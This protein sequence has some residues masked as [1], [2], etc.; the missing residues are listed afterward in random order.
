MKKLILIIICLAQT[1]IFGQSEA[2]AVHSKFKILKQN[3]KSPLEV[4]AACLTCHNK[5]HLEIMKSSHWTWERKNPLPTR[6]EEKVLGK[7]NLLNNFCIGIAGSEGTCTKCHIGYGWT[8]EIPT[9]DKNLRFEKYAEK[10][11]NRIDCLVCHDNSGTYKKAKGKSGYPKPDINLSLVAQNIGKPTNENCGSCHFFS[12]G[13]NNVK[14]GDLEKALLTCSRKVDIHMSEDGANLDCIDCHK[15]ENHNITGQLYSVSSTNEDRAKCEACHTTTPH[16]DELLNTHYKKISCQTCHI[17]T[18]AKANAT[19]I[20]WD[21]STAGKLNEDDKPYHVNDADGN[22]SYLSIKGSFKWGKNLEPEYI[23]FNG[24]ADHYLLGDK[25]NTDNLPLKINDLKGSYDANSKIIPVKIHKGKQIYDP[26]NKILIQPK[27]WDKKKGNG[28][29]WTDF[30]W[31]RAAEEGMK[32]VGLPYSGKYDF[33]ETEMYWPINHMV[34]PAEEALDC[35]SCHNPNNSRL[36]K[37]NNFYLPG[38]DNNQFIDIFGYLL[39]F[40]TLS[41]VLLH[42]ILRFILQKKYK[43]SEG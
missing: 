40:G 28:A 41:G 8:D 32:I 6:K 16:T 19:K 23:W 27:L 4:T 36:A 43:K 10:H 38:R 11:K 14:H 30:D 26:V 15:T 22:H 39:V 37:L 20:Y 34:A 21:W 25:I 31:N 35:K 13:G 18:Y 17:P 1:V 42:L 12:G 29:F 9:E 33:I 7:I 3:F 2:A 5:R 24:T